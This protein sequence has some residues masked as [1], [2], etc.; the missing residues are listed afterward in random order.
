[1]DKHVF[2]LKVL[3]NIRLIIKTILFITTKILKNLY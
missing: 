2:I 1:M 3:L